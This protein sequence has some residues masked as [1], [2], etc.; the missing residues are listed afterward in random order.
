MADLNAL[1][2]SLKTGDYYTRASAARALG[3]LGGDEAAGALI[4]ALGD[5]DDWVQE[6]AADALGKLKYKPAIPPLGQLLASDYY[7]I[8]TAAAAA[9]GHIGGDEARELLESLK[10]DSDSWVREAAASALRTLDATPDE[11]PLAPDTDFAE[12]PIPAEIIA[13]PV[14]G[15][16]PADPRDFVP[17]TLEDISMD[18]VGGEPEDI[19]RLVARGPAIK[20]KEV[21]SGYLLKVDVGAGRSQRVRLS[22]DSVDEDNSPIIQ[23]FSIIGPARKEHYRW[24]LKLNPTFSYGAIGL[25]KIDG[26]DML[27]AIDTVL[28]EGPNIAALKKSVMTIA[29]MADSLEK[30]LIKKDLW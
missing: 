6:Y 8:R 15:D 3:E 20:Y 21:K 4:V 24:A 17:S 28:A 23:I 22:F 29:R 19:V 26:K 18:D 9:L 14:V 27:A 7:K 13:A 5:E 16:L 30:K 11:S 2:E 10:D 25:V 1:I 12:S